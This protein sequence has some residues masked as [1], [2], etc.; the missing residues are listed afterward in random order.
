[1]SDSMVRRWVRDFN[2]GRGNVNDDQRSGRPSV[3]NED[4]VHAREEKFQENRRFTISSLSVHFP[5]IPRSLLHEILSEKLR[6][7]RFCSR[8]VPKMLTDEH[9]MKRQASALTFLTRY[10]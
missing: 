7:R 5:Q 9:K 8:W 3:V 1:V 4:L 6:F 2:E 10:S